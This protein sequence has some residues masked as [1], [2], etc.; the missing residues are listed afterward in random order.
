MSKSRSS[1]QE[2][3]SK[4]GVIGNFAKFTGILNP[5]QVFSCEFY[6]ISQNTFSYRTPPVAASVNIMNVSIWLLM[7]KKLPD[8]EGCQIK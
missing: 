5:A 7:W 6:K 3:S 8:K 1:L 2:L 4:K